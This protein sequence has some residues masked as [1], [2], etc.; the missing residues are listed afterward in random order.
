MTATVE[1]RRRLAPEQRKRML[2]ACAV[3]V[4]SRRGIGRGGHTE[5]AE[6]AGVSVATVFNYFKTR[7]LLV[8]EVLNEVGNF[9]ASLADE[10]FEEQTAPTERLKRFIQAFVQACEQHPAYI[11][12]WLEWGSSLRADI[13]PQFV[14]MRLQLLEIWSEQI[15]QAIDE[16]ALSD[17]L[18]ASERALWLIGN[19]Q[20]LASLM[21]DPTGKPDNMSDLTERFTQHLLQI[22]RE[23]PEAVS[24]S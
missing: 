14:L 3:E 9:I 4:F 6:S 21:F 22:N 24:M 19:C 17:G 2:L 20:T 10:A 8:E 13:W 7:E 16:G 12:V 23:Y 5:I 11:K 15:Q 18:P 1:G